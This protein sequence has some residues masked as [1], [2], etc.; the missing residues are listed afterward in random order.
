MIRVSHSSLDGSVSLSPEPNIKLTGSKSLDSERD[1]YPF[2]N[3]ERLRRSA[4]SALK[5]GQ[6]A[7]TETDVNQK[8]FAVMIDLNYILELR[9]FYIF[10]ILDEILGDEGSGIGSKSNFL[11]KLLQ[12]SPQI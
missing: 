6:T 3:D 10:L 7:N 11:I 8:I 1:R 9:R 12:L 4:C 2:W 5:S